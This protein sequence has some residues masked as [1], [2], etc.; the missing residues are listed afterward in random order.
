MAEAKS[1]TQSKTIVTN[2]LTLL[3]SAGAIFGVDFGLDEETK[4][5]IAAGAVALLSVVNIV[6]RFVTSSGIRLG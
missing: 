2:A 5:T 3:A 4:G 1:A 6:L